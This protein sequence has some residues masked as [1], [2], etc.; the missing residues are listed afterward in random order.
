M[1]K[2]RAPKVRIWPVVGLCT[3]PL[4]CG[5]DG[6]QAGDSG[7]SGSQTGI[8]ISETEAV[9]DDGPKFD[10][11]GDGTAGAD[12]GNNPLGCKKVDV[13]VAVDNSDSMV[14]EHEALRGPVFDS[15]PQTLLAINGGIDDFHL[16]VIDACPKPAHFHDT[17]L[18]GACNF[19]TGSNMMISSSPTL[20]DEFACVT[21]FSPNG[22]Q[23]E[24]D[25][26]VDDGD[27]ADDDE[28]PALTAANA[29]TGDALLG[30]NAGFLR[31]DAVLFIVAITDEDE[32]LAD[33][34]S[35]QEIYDR[36]VAAKGGD[37]S[38]VVYLGV[39]GDSE[40]EGPYGTALDAVQSK[41]LAALFE[42]NGNGMF[43]D[44][45]MGDLE[46]AFEVA[47]EGQVDSACVDFPNAG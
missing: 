39:G 11:G 23:G 38:K 33:V 6:G 37:A 42:A 22:Y 29:I 1:W 44:L 3:L 26:C 36:I 40:C 2:A 30:A 16:A 10:V 24:S 19:S 17:G 34:E 4:A 28:Q 14:E 46:T 12:D 47:I 5:D 31:E 20:A 21:E 35:A 45:C 9:E 7:S 27:F 18:D 32:E 13:I 8:V 15:F 25:N 43:W 41:E